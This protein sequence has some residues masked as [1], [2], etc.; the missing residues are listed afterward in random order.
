MKIRQH[1]LLQQ[2]TYSDHILAIVSK[3]GHQRSKLHF[4]SYFHTL[5]F[6]IFFLSTNYG[7]LIHVVSVV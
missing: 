7:I 6:T 2:K 1:F 4:A 3:S 5:Y